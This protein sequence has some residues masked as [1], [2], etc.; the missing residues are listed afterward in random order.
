[1]GA[2]D[3]VFEAEGEAA[4][5]VGRHGGSGER[6]YRAGSGGGEAEGTYGAGSYFAAF[7]LT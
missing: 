4:K 2:L 3:R 6:V 7:R 1:V 5:G